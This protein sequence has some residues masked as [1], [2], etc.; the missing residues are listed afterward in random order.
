[1]IR[2]CAALVFLLSAPFVQAEMVV[3]FESELQ[4]PIE[5]RARIFKAH[6]PKSLVFLNKVAFDKSE[7][8]PTRWRAVTTMGRV[9]ASYFRKDLDR[10]LV[11]PEWFMRNAALIALLNDE[12]ERA[13]T[14][15]TRLL[16]DPALMVRTQ[17]VRNL[18][19]LNAR[20]SEG[21]LWEEVSSRRNF[22]GRESLWI[23]AHIAEALASFAGPGRA[24]SFEKLLL[25]EDT[26]LHRWAIKGLE[27]STGLKLGGGRREPVEVRR[28]QWLSRL[29]IQEL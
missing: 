17:A 28:Q 8:I 4:K 16:S 3:S 6:R 22:K 1:M 20:E 21:R 7:P 14:M 5:A 19:A 12:R 10:A 27:A 13:V 29:G 15:S 23:R 18:I 25:D 9:D 24:K 2:R 11:S 26:R